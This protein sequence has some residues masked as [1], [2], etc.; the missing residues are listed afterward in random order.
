M[1]TIVGVFVA[2]SNKI[3]VL[4]SDMRNLSARVEK[5]NNVVERTYKVETELQTC[6]KRHDELSDRVD[7]LENAKIGGSE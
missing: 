1:I 6:W 3:A 5:H 7:R 4:Q 2:L